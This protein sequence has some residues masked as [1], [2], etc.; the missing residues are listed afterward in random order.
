VA[1]KV[2]N[3]TPEH[4]KA[5]EEIEREGISPPWKCSARPEMPFGTVRTLRRYQLHRDYSPPAWRNRATAEQKQVG[6]EMAV[7]IEKLLCVVLHE[8][9][10]QQVEEAMETLAEGP[11]EFYK[12]YIRPRIE[13]RLASLVDAKVYLSGRTSYPDWSYLL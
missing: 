10:M 1:G 3:P 8:A 11:E 5:L 4:L 13:P 6:W 12:S 7:R 2:I 9:Y